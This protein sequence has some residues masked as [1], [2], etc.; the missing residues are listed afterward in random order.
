MTTNGGDELEECAICG[1]ELLPGSDTYK[2]S[3]NHTYHK[4]CIMLEV[5][6]TNKSKYMCPYCR[7][8]IKNVPLF[9]Y[10]I[11]IKGV[12]EEYQKYKGKYLTHQEFKQFL[13]SNDDNRRCEALVF[14][15]DLDTKNNGKCFTIYNNTRQCCRKKTKNG[16]YFCS[17][18]NK[19]Y[20]NVT[21]NN[22]TYYFP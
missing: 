16:D 9:E 1:D 5:E 2:L 19:K 20:K 22:V 7:T 17:Q 6:S 21:M 18:H 8:P 4:T 3:C 13:N 12:H 11:P 14:T 15:T 10:Q